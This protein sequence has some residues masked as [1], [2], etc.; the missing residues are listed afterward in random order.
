MGPIWGPQT[1]PK[2]VRELFFFGSVFRTLF[3]EV[4]K[5]FKCLLGAFLSLLCSSWEPPRSEKYGF[6]IVKS[7]FLKM[8]FLGTLRLLMSSLESSWL[9]LAHSNPKRTPKR[10]PKWTQNGPKMKPE[11]VQFLVPFLSTFW[12]ILGGHF[13]TQKSTGE[14]C[15]DSGSVVLQC[16]NY[17]FCKNDM[18]FM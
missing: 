16:K 9:I 15:S 11:V 8:M 7:H 6:P 13:G 14:I 10:T 17:I 3:Y 5:L 18:I 2:I 1:A 4:L 12:T